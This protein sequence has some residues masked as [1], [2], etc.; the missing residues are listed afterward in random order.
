MKKFA[1]IFIFLFIALFVVSCAGDN[2]PKV[3]TDVAT[4]TVTTTVVT[5]KAVSLADYTVVRPDVNS[6]YL[7]NSATYL[8]NY[9]EKY[10][11][12][13]LKV[14]IDDVK[15]DESVDDKKEILIGETGRKESADAKTALAEKGLKNSFIIRFTDNKI[16]I[17]GSGEKETAK[18]V[19]YFCENYLKNGFTAE[20]AEY[21]S[22]ELGELSILENLVEF[23][24]ESK[25]KIYGPTLKDQNINLKYTSVI[26][27]K[28]SESNN[29]TLIATCED[30]AYN[31]YNIRRSTDGGKTWEKIAEV[32]E[33]FYPDMYIANWC[34]SLYELPYKVGEME[35]GT[36]LLSATTRDRRTVEATRTTI[37]KSTDEGVTWTELP[38]VDRGFGGGRGMYEPFLVA[39]EKGELV[40]FYSDETEVNKNGGQR[41]VYKVSTDGETWGKKQ[42]LIAPE[43]KSKRPGM[44]IVTPLDDGRYMLVYEM[45]GLNDGE[46]YYKI[47]DDLTDW[48]D[49]TKYGT[50]IKA[51]NG[52]AP[53]ATPYVTYL[54]D[55]G[56]NGALIL[57]SWRMSGSDHVYS[58]I[59]ISTDFGKT[60]YTVDNPLPYEYNHDMGYGYSP[61][62]AEGE[63]GIVYYTNNV[64]AE[65]GDRSD[66]MIAVLKIK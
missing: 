3:T 61:C 14:S 56:I 46:L 55:V 17:L 10:L 62:F 12:A 21:V 65:Y 59:F 54:P 1:I 35:A 2:S 57:S 45:V 34:P 15:K 32:G 13:D 37:W 49:Y 39:N 47:T 16:V 18:G 63:N 23:S 36:L 4:T 64:N 33:Q 5:T 43:D 53:H 31:H 27:L 52:S 8:K 40:C 44:P 41:L 9:A 6:D 19:K 25:T 42:Y 30:Y 22:E 58:D 20:P 7:K 38:I 51:K 11:E 48:G 29:G 60:W 26:V 50:A 66:M 28:H 24:V